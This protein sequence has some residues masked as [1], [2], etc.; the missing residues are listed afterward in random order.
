MSK[1]KL[2]LLAIL[3]VLLLVVGSIVML[4]L[5]GPQTAFVLEANGN[6]GVRV[7]GEVEVDGVLK[8]VEGTLPARFPLEGKR[9]RFRLV[10]DDPKNETNLQVRVFIN[11]AEEMSAISR[12]GVEGDVHRPVLLGPLRGRG[13]IAS[14]QDAE[15][16]RLQMQA[17]K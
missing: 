3:A 1:N 2:L 11:G 9:V 10:A 17:A 15:Q 6:P 14:L 7:L 16:F 13:M 5:F 12:P 4:E 8:R